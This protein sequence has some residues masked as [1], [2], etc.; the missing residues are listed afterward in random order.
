MIVAA[1]ARAVREGVPTSFV[2]ADAQTHRFESASFD[3]IIP[4]LGVM[5]L[6][7]P[8]A[9]FSN[10]RRAARSKAKLR[11]VAWRSAAENP[12]MTPAERAAAPLLPNLPAHRPGAPGQFAFADEQRVRRILESS[13]WGDVEIRPLDAPCILPE[14]ELVL[15]ITRLGP[16]G[17]IL[18]EANPTKRDR[19]VQTVRHAFDPYVDGGQV[20]FNAACWM[21]AARAASGTASGSGCPDASAR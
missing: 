11:F 16:L 2:C 19:I 7:D 21:V 18:H 14:S 5:F 15:Y 4:R 17:L 12:F 1:R 10:L 13:G 20:R 6:N 3:A 8:A 9:A